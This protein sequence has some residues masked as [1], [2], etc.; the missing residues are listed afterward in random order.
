[1]LAISYGSTCISVLLNLST[2]GII[3]QTIFLLGGHPVNLGCLVVSLASPLN[4]SKRRLPSCNKQNVSRHCLLFPR[5]AKPSPVENHCG[6]AWVTQSV[7][8]PTLDF[9]SGH[10]LTFRKVETHIRL[11]TDSMEPAWDSPFPSLSLPLP[12]SLSLSLSLS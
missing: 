7:K 10:D 9:S 1:M 3:S 5:G 8:H 11:C 6:G 12:S 2:T 4:V